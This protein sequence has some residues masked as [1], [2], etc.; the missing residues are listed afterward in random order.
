MHHYFRHDGQIE[1]SQD[2]VLDVVGTARM[3]G[4]FGYRSLMLPLPGSDIGS[5]CYRGMCSLPGPGP[6][7]PCLTDPDFLSMV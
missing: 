5:N 1:R 2:L 6:G 3:K 7:P 4:D